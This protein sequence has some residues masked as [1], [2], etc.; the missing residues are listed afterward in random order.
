MQ[1]IPV[2]VVSG[3]YFPYQR[4]RFKINELTGR[5]LNIENGQYGIIGKNEYNV[6]VLVKIIDKHQ[7]LTNL[8][9]NYAEF[10]VEAIQR[11]RINKVLMKPVDDNI[12]K[13]CEVE[14]IDD[15]CPSKFDEAKLKE[16]KEK[17]VKLLEIYQSLVRS[18][19]KLVIDQV[20]KI[21]N[22]KNPV[23]TLFLVASF[24]R[25]ENKD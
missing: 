8:V 19:T 7:I 1:T 15:Q 23:Q 17:A 25:Y 4:L 10:S 11:F 12:I 20:L 21:N 9:S 13:V 2:A 24:I 5:Q 22:S 18:Q 3:V 16:V 14:M 6:G